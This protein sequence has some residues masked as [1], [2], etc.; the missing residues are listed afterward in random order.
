MRIVLLGA[1]G[2]GKGTQAKK[3]MDRY[4]IPQIST[5][6]ILRAAVSEGTELGLKAKA[7]MDAGRLVAD[8]I[9]VGMIRERL[10]QPDARKGFV[11]DGFPRSL[12]QAKALDRELESLG[13]PLDHA[14]LIHVETE[15]LMKRLTGRRT[16]KACG[17]MF[18]VYFNPPK[19][20][21]VC[22]A[23]GGEL[24]QRDDDN[25]EVIANRLRVYEEQTAP[26]VDYYDAQG[27]L[28][29]I[30]GVGEMEEVFDRLL[31]ALDA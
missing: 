6:D 15:A 23:C 27:L 25:E 14:V 11:L 2:S 31:G 28:Q 18:N 12:P 26:L 16:C 24:Q 3:L 19:V 20:Q 21:G 5:G 30:E 29:R 22:D 1:P 13:Q 9:V 8:E 4:G 17:H 10:K 7:A